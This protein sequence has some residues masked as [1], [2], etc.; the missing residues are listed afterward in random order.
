MFGVFLVSL[1]QTVV[2][3]LNCDILGSCFV[4][5]LAHYHYDGCGPVKER[6]FTAYSKQTV[7]Y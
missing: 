1:L 6:G 7:L 2:V 4:N 3:T 5:V